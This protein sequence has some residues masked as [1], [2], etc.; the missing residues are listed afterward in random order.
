MGAGRG[1]NENILKSWIFVQRSTE[2]RYGLLE[3]GFAWHVL[4]IFFVATI[5][6]WIFTN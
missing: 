6:L 5:G 1:E 4:G 2:K 3:C